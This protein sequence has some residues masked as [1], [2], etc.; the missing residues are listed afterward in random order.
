MR[1]FDWKKVARRVSEY[2]R[3]ALAPYL[4][5]YLPTFIH[6]AKSSLYD[7][8]AVERDVS[9]RMILPTTP[10]P[11]CAHCLDSLYFSNN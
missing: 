10:L 9:M 6:R 5:T 7:T 8:F 11:P 4:P 3:E 2:F 1:G